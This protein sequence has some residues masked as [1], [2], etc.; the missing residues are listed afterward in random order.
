MVSGAAGSFWAF[1]DWSLGPL[2]GTSNLQRTTFVSSK[3]RV[4]A[5]AQA[6]GEELARLVQAQ[7]VTEN[8]LPRWK[9]GMNSDLMTFKMHPWGRVFLEWFFQHNS[10]RETLE[11]KR[12]V[13]LL[14]C[15]PLK[16]W[17]GNLPV[18]KWSCWS[19]STARLK[20]CDCSVARTEVFQ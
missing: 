12:P 7:T 1:P 18:L 3:D 20:K 9:D 15:R 5:S 19:F 10:C 4:S 14:I 16:N 13:D 8:D 11:S 17:N 6:L 2:K